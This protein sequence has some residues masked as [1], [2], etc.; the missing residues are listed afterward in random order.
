MAILP[1]VQFA[2]RD[3][4]WRENVSENAQSVIGGDRQFCALF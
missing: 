4:H 2:E 1:I 3:A